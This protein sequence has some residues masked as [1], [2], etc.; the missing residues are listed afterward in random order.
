MDK[1]L[2]DSFTDMQIWRH[3]CVCVCVCVRA[4]VR[5]LSARVSCCEKTYEKQA[6]NINKPVLILITQ[7]LVRDHFLADSVRQTLPTD[8]ATTEESEDKQEDDVRASSMSH[9][10]A[11]QTF[12]V[13]RALQPIDRIQK[14]LRFTHSQQ[15]YTFPHYPSPPPTPDALP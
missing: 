9:W 13:A 8:H 1:N 2:T 10:A 3:V 14:P 15:R 11:Q 7:K 5:E 4:C 12:L 6:F